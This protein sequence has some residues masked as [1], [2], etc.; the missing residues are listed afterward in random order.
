MKKL[1][2]EW[3]QQHPMPAKPTTEQRLQ[4]HWEHAQHCACRPIPPALLELLKQRG[5][6]A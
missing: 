5:L 3:H 1:N 2:A 6:V 4:W